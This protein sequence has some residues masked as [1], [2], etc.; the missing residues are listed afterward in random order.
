MECFTGCMGYL[1]RSQSREVY[2]EEQPCSCGE[3]LMD[4]F[5]INN[6]AFVVV[7]ALLLFLGGRSK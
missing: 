7:V 1:S 5:A 2:S 6:I 4:Y 3:G